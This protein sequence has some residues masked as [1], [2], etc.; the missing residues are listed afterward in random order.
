MIKLSDLAGIS[1]RKYFI[2]IGFG[3][4]QFSSFP[5]SYYLPVIWVKRER[6]LRP[7]RCTVILETQSVPSGQNIFC[8]LRKHALPK[9]YSFFSTKIWNLLD[10]VEQKN[11][12]YQ[13]FIKSV[14]FHLFVRF[15]IIFHLFIQHPF[16]IWQVTMRN[17]EPIIIFII[18]FTISFFFTLEKKTFPNEH[19][20]TCTLLHCIPVW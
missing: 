9:H 1:Q 20:Y 10:N 8:Y 17:K 19:N 6:K 13:I 14:I 18:F 4:C 2:S 12:C 7:N 5:S 15:T 11:Q 16:I 3:K